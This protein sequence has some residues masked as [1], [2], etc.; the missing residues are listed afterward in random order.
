MGE[1]EEDDDPLGCNTY[2]KMKMMIL[3]AATR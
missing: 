2:E 1:D 3:S